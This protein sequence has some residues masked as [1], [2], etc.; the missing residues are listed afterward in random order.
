M[1]I[2]AED[3]SAADKS[4]IGAYFSSRKIMQ[5]DG[6]G[7]KPLV[8]KLFV[9]GDQDRGLPS[10]V[11]CHG[12][13]GKGRVAGKVVYPVIGGQRAVYLR[14]QLVVWKLGDR[15][16][17]PGGVMNKVAQ[18]LSDDEIDALADYISGL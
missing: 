3:L 12:E 5:G 16:N 1:T 11:S 4:D 10:C 2:M 14:T 18:A 9:N 6:A 7:D 13:S 8:R 17:S 15:N